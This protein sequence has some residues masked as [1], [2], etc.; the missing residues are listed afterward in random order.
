MSVKLEL[1]QSCSPI[2]ERIIE[3]DVSK[4]RAPAV[5]QS[6]SPTVKRIIKIYVS[7]TSAPEIVQS[8]S[9]KSN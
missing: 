9:R 1:L 6:C 3:I 8:H 4:T 5:L 7:K 2:V